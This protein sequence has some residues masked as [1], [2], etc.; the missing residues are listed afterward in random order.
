MSG[1]RKCREKGESADFN[2][3]KYH[4]RLALVILFSAAAGPA[5]AFLA[6]WVNRA[7]FG[8]YLWPLIGSIWLFVFAA[9]GYF[10][11]EGRGAMLYGGCSAIG[12]LCAIVQLALLF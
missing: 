8:F 12:A 1:S 2:I 9:A 4:I 11:A 3:V 6:A 10:S 5:G 7:R